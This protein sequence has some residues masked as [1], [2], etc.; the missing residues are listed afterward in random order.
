MASTPPPLEA[1]RAAVAKNAL[2]SIPRLLWPPASQ[3]E[4]KGGLKPN[5]L[6]W[7]LHFWPLLAPPM[8]HRRP[9]KMAKLFHQMELKDL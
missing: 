6:T 2:W 8:K 5:I 9:E 4:R 7:L 1:L 3:R